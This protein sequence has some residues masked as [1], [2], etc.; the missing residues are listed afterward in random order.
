MARQSTN[1]RIKDYK[2]EL[3][4]AIRQGSMCALPIGMPEIEVYPRQIREYEWEVVCQLTTAIVRLNISERGI[5]DIHPAPLLDGT[6]GRFA[7][8][9]VADWF[10][11]LV[12]AALDY[13]STSHGRMLTRLSDGSTYVRYTAN[14]CFWNHE[15]AG[16]SSFE[17]VLVPRMQGVY[18]KEENPKWFKPYG[19]A[20]LNK[21]TTLPRQVKAS[22]EQSNVTRFI[23]ALGGTMYAQN[24]HIAKP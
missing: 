22:I 5:K 20:R 16:E 9:S 6:I 21:D 12:R 1:S 3:T 13:Q 17:A 14:Y 8:Q 10:E 7:P 18:S 19:G 23:Y 2:W 11:I 24:Q 4:E 15:D